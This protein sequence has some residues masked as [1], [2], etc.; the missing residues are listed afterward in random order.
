MKI[1]AK[2]RLGQQNNNRIQTH[3]LKQKN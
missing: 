3:L 2:V 1:L